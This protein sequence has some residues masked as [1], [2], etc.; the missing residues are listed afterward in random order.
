YDVRAFELSRQ[1]LALSVQ[2]A[3]YGLVTQKQ[4]IRNRESSLASFEF[5]KRRSDR[6]FDLGRVSEVDKFR[7][8]REYLVA[9]NDLVDARQSYEASADRFKI[10]LGVEATTKL[11][12]AE[13][14]PSPRPLDLDLRRA[15]D[16]ALVNR[17]DLMT[18]RDS[19]EDAE[20]R[21]RIG[22]RN[23]LPD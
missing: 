22:E 15:I 14:I 11:D 4:V 5:L 8:A 9:E 12:V 18:S 13:E 20:R 21:L 2:S 16:V 6:L 19:V 10:L 3:F 7:A 17:L 23:L 1:G